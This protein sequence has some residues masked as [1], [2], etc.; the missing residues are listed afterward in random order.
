MTVETFVFL[1]TIKRETSI[2]CVDFSIFLYG[3]F[4][5]RELWIL[6]ISNVL[7]NGSDFNLCESFKILKFVIVSVFQVRYFRSINVY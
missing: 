1:W 2:K 3:L 7:L 4:N 6:S 5:C